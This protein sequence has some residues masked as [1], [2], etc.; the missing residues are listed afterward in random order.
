[1]TQATLKKRI[2]QAL[3]NTKD[4]ELLQAVYTILKRTVIEQEITSLTATQ[5]KELD[6]RLAEHKS[7]KLKYYTLEEVKKT[8]LKALKK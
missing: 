6:Q 4:D 1:M 5:K 2:Q 8:T 3:D 7:G